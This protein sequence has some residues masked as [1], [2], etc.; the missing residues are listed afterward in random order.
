MS[1]LNCIHLLHKRL[2]PFHSRTGSN[3]THTNAARTSAFEARHKNGANPNFWRSYGGTSA[4]GISNRLC[5]T[6]AY[7]VEITGGQTLGE[8][9]GL[10]E[11]G[12][13]VG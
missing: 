11:K 8:R 7:V 13:D 5:K 3:N 2:A 10:R 4:S 9:Q 6:M 1:V 12:K